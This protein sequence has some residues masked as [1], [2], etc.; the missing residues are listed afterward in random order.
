MNK[1][2]REGQ[3]IFIKKEVHQEDILILKTVPQTQGHP[4]LKKKQYDS[5]IHILILKC[6][7]W[8]TS[9]PHY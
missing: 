2:Y 3:Y 9:L 1:K 7:Q 8:E 5:F 4:T 6:W